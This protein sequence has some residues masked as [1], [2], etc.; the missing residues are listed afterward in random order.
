[1]KLT[2]KQLIEG[3][4]GRKNT[5]EEIYDKEG[6]TKMYIKEMLRLTFSVQMEI[7]KGK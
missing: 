2:K 4:E 1:M 7:L 3:F 5:I 6:R